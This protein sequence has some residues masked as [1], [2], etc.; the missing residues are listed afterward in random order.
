LKKWFPL[1]NRLSK[2]GLSFDE[3]HGGDD[4][5]TLMVGEKNFHVLLF[6]ENTFKGFTKNEIPVG[7]QRSP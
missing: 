7:G 1:R 6:A 3:K 4:M 5:A 2:L